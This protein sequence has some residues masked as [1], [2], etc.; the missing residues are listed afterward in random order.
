[1][2]L[3]ET[4][5]QTFGRVKFKV[6]IISKAA[7]Y[8]IKIYVLTNAETAFVIKVIVYMGKH[9]YNETD[10]RSYA[11]TWREIVEQFTLIDVTHQ[12]T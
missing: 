10:S 9:T 12:L 7:R 1:M 5:I 3:E 8:G 2:S 4:L 11:S 6:R